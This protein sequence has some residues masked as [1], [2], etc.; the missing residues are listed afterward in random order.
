MELIVSLKGG[1]KVECSCCS[2]KVKISEIK[3]VKNNYY[4][5]KCYETISGKT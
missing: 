3:K 5:P 1:Y 4:C 2:A